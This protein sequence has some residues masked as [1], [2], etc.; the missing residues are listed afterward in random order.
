VWADPYWDDEGAVRT[1]YTFADVG[2]DGV[3]RFYAA[4]YDEQ[5]CALYDVARE[6]GLLSTGSVDVHGH[7]HERVNAFRAFELYGLE[8]NLGRIGAQSW[9]TTS[10]SRSRASAR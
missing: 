3:E 4:H 2:I 8:P 1:L 10:N 6:R 9:A 5:T 7:G